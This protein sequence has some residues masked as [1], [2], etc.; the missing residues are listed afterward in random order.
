MHFSMRQKRWASLIL[1]LLIGAAGIQLGYVQGYAFLSCHSMENVSASA[2]VRAAARIAEAD[3]TTETPIWQK[4]R[5]IARAERARRSGTY[6]GL[7]LGCCH[8]VGYSDAYIRIFLSSC[9]LEFVFARSHA[10]MMAYIHC[11][12]G[13]NAFG[14]F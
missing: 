6:R 8:A 11:Q 5:Y 7:F 9:R 10:L 13:E 2:F 12:D 1:T 4:L 14:L 3:K